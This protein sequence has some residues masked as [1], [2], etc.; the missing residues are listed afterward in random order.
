MIEIMIL[1]NMITNYIWI[2]ATE[3]T[4]YTRA[5]YSQEALVSQDVVTEPHWLEE[6]EDIM[7][8]LLN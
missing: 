6:F 1:L 8:I 5:P 2:E 7:D 3:D 4:F